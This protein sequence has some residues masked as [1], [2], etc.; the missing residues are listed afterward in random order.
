MAV[1][2]SAPSSESGARA[3]GRGEWLPY[4]LL[5][6]KVQERWWHSPGHGDWSTL[7]ETYTLCTDGI[8]HKVL[9]GGGGVMRLL[10]VVSGLF[11][12]ISGLFWVFW[13]LFWSVLRADFEAFLVFLWLIFDLR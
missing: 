1:S 7:L 4:A 5:L 10:G 2:S 8:F 11:R 6:R 9:K 12:V 3:P 13:S